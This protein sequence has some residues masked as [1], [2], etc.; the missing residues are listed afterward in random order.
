MKLF[1]TC[2]ILFCTSFLTAQN[3]TI[4]SLKIVLKTS[5]EDTLKVK[6]L[7]SLAENFNTA[8]KP[9]SAIYYTGIA[10]DLAQKVKYKRGQGTALSIRGTSNLNK[11]KSPE[12]LQLFK[13]A[14]ILLEESGDKTRLAA[15]ILNLGVA[16]VRIANYSAAREQL[17]AGLKIYTELNNKLGM[18]NAYSNLGAADVSQAKYA[19]ASAYFEKAKKMHEELNNKIGVANCLNN[20]GLMAQYQGNYTESLEKNAASLKIRE[21][22]GD[23]NG[24][25]TS[26]LN[27]GILFYYKSEYTRA[28]EEFNIAYK[29]AQ[30]VGNKA[31]LTNALNNLASVTIELGDY[32]ASMTTLKMVLK[33]RE[34]MNDKAGAGQALM[35]IGINLVKQSK[36]REALPYYTKSLK[37]HKEI[38]DLKNAGSAYINIGVLYQFQGNYPM[39]LQNY[40]EAL[41]L[42]QETN[43][44]MGMV[45]TYNNI[46]TTYYHQG[47]FS[48]SVKNFEYSLKISEELNDKKAMSVNH[49]NLGSLYTQKSNYTE[50]LKHHNIAFSIKKEIGDKEGLGVT[51]TN[52][53]DVYLL[54]KKYDEALISF[55]NALQIGEEIGEKQISGSAEIN[56]GT[57]K[58]ETGQYAEAKKHGLNAVA[59]SKTLGAPE[60]SKKSNGLLSKVYF[61]ENNLPEAEKYAMEVLRIC[62][63]GILVN[64]PIMSEKEQESYFNTLLPD[65][66]AFNTLAL[67]SKEKNPAITEMVYNS[68]VR[69]KGLLLKSSSATRNAIL[70]SKDTALIAKYLDWVVVKKQ[71]AKLYSDGKDATE[72]EERSNL[73]EKELVKNSQVFSSF[74]KAQKITW[75]NVQESLKKEEAAIEFVHFDI[76]DKKTDIQQIVY[77]AL[78]VKPGSK[79]PEMVR[80]CTGKDLEIVMGKTKETGYGYIKSLYG[81]NNNANTQ[82]YEMIW[83]PL[84]KHL[85]GC[86]SV[87]ISPSGL[88]HKISFA[89]L[90][91]SKNVYLCD[92]YKINVQTST[93]KVAFPENFVFDENISVAIFGGVNYENEK[94]LSDSNSFLTWNYL[95]GTLTEASSIYSTLQKNKISTK[96]YKDKQATEAE[97]KSISTTNSILHIATHGFFFPDLEDEE[98]S[99]ETDDTKN[100]VASR[101]VEYGFGVWS[102]VANKNPL[103][104]SGLVFAGANGVWNQ[105]EQSEDED[106]VLTAQ[107]VANLDMRQTG[108]VVLSACETG[109]GDIKGS[110]GVYGLQR[111]FKMA[112]AKFIIMSLWQVPDAETEEFMSIF[113]KKLVAVKNVKKAFSDSQMAMRKE[114]DPFFWAPF[115]L[116]E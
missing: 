18:A 96:L 102:F 52:I 30:E 9:D 79:Y 87:Y 90:C 104:R 62:N 48:E 56:I 75:K 1:I 54:Q 72:L 69:N 105:T 81:T 40:A 107:E 13:D 82:L 14:I 45:Q 66:M 49:N 26:H 80:L 110:E 55:S 4:D 25:S 89:A 47:N 12:A 44:K 27:L 32:E 71:I 33:M 99:A 41:K 39:A 11:G 68:A 98:Q 112:G 70:N 15:T 73:L 53:G 17:E 76:N 6:T 114:Y 3:K 7:N 115:V 51:H 91:K 86:K 43:D 93:G 50:A 100:E 88:L 19:S 108:L 92:N 61:R 111:S 2:T 28:K 36:Y 113:Y 21:E 24:Q 84:E 97:F 78:V 20:I 60:L 29:L 116:I 74:D 64:F 95:P 42:K 57:V 85:S 109:L 5:K 94:A 46:G 38:G 10:Q 63:K 31:N 59:I 35:N 16:Y 23:K 58:M 77:C 22:I 65:F 34:E 67:L 103:M 101:G 106:G 83:A 37:I 8:F